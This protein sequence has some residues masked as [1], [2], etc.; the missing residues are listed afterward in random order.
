M[1]SSRNP[2]LIEYFHGQFVES[3]HRGCAI[4]MNEQGQ[5]EFSL[6]D[7]D[8]VLCIRSALKPLQTLALVESGAYDAFSLTPRELAL[9]AGS[10][11]GEP[12]HT[13]TVLNWLDKLDVP[14]S[15]LLCGGDLPN[16]AEARQQVIREGTPLT[17]K[18]NGCSGKHAG[19]LT[20]ARHLNVVI[21]G[22]CDL[23]HPVQTVIIEGITRRAG[24]KLEDVVMNIDYCNAP[25]FYMPLSA[26]ARAY[27]TMLSDFKNS[28]G[29]ESG[30]II[31]AMIGN[32]E[33]V[34]GTLQYCSRCMQAGQGK[35]AAKC[36]AEGAMLALLPEDGLVLLVKIDDGAN[37][38]AEVLMTNILFELGL[39]SHD[40]V[41]EL[42]NDLVRV[43]HTS[44]GKRMGYLS[45]HKT[46]LSRRAH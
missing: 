10:H 42:N 31:S 41:E 16:N 25:N 40:T 30:Q 45:L 9:A 12:F 35:V 34:G 14:E 13:E 6:G 26:F 4:V 23:D 17:Q 33:Y 11:D 5:I 24:V 8:Q 46:V 19:F 27:T 3:Q 7:P 20:I 15:A 32:P 37:R 28:P 38:A 44:S 39:I 43:V 2:V 1:I 21:N 18:F 29:N 22:Y 36:G